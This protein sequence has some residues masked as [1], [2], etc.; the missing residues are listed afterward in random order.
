MTNP[1]LATYLLRDGAGVPLV[2]LHGFPLDH[3]MWVAMV[4]ELPQ[5]PRVIAVDLPGHGHSDLGQLPASLDATADLVH[6]TLREQ[7]E[8]NAVVVGLSMG[9]YVA[10][11]MAERHP[12]FVRGLGLVDTKSTAD[13]D[14]ARDGRL[15]VAAAVEATQTLDAVMGM[16]AKLLGPTSELERRS[17]YPTV[18]AWIRSQ[19]LSGV[20]WA[21]RAMA[22]RPDRTD[23][24]RS[25][26]GPVAVV[27]G[28]EDQVTT[29][30][31]ARHMAG[32]ARD[33]TLA[34]VPNAAHLSAVEEPAAVA[35]AVADLHARVR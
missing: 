31:D 5:G 32:A 27:V 21:Q 23:V 24:L 1:T 12:G 28:A 13:D 22:A 34:V 3:R 29:V 33:A 2:L 26:G 7:G 30:D 18:Y 10:L 6:A 25:F 17:L 4:D 11:A 20:A 14:A 35:R 15:R 8:G 16:P 19:G 9:G